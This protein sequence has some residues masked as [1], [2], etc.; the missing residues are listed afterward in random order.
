MSNPNP[1]IGPQWEPVRI[2]ALLPPVRIGVDLYLIANRD[3]RPRLY[4]GSQNPPSGDDLER[5][6]VNGIGR[7]YVRTD[8][9]ALLRAQ[10]SELLESGVDL[11]AGLRLEMLREV[12]KADFALAWRANSAAALT[13]HA[14]QFARQIVDICDD[15]D[16][17]TNAL[18]SLSQ[19]DGD[20][21]H[22]IS[23]VC[24][25]AV[26]LAQALGMTDEQKLLEVGQ[27]ALLHDIGKRSVRADILQKPGKLTPAE[28]EIISDHPRLGFLEL[29]RDPTL[30]REQLLAIYQHHERLDGSGYPVR[31]VGN[32]IN[33]LAQLCAV[34]DVYEA[35]TGTRP[36]RTASPAEEAIATLQRAGG[37]HYNEEYLQ[38]WTKLVGS[39]TLARA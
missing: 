2:G 4:S 23:N 16:E 25:Y 15:R 37:R 28:R 5:L 39:S 19:H 21:F 14:A 33:W 22:H 17:M 20:T 1:T 13:A 34:V 12:V 7:L 24:V 27:A 31:L 9:L 32:E 30:T 38:C 3:R 26:M 6:Q 10:L 35:L 18:A 36:Y 29:S 8:Q 11:P